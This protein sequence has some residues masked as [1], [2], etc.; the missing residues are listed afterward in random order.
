MQLIYTGCES[1]FYVNILKYVV[2]CLTQLSS[3]C[4]FFMC[5]TFVSSYNS[6]N[7]YN[8]FSHDNDDLILFHSIVNNGAFFIRF[9]ILFPLIPSGL[10]LAIKVIP[11]CSQQKSHFIHFRHYHFRH[12]ISDISI[13]YNNL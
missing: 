3:R 2:T 4:S 5:D 11:L 7:L 13:S 10:L 12:F 8:H 6:L 9:K 1:H